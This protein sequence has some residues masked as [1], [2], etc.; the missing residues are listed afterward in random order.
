[1]I[2]F[3][4]R[5][6]PGAA[7]EYRRPNGCGVSTESG[8]LLSAHAYA[9]IVTGGRARC[10]APPSSPCAAAWVHEPQGMR[11][12]MEKGARTGAPGV[13]SRRCSITAVRHCATALFC[14]TDEEAER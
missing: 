1:M 4:P 11:P 12:P 6:D 10:T 3:L 9:P 14:S 2:G 13:V 8:A 5:S 7:T